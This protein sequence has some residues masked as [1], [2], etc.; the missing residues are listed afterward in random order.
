MI[1]SRATMTAKL[2][3]IGLLMIASSASALVAAEPGGKVDFAND[4][5]PILT[6]QCVECHGPK[7]QENG[8]RLDHG[9]A[10]VRGGD[11]GPAVVAGK[12]G[13]SLLIQAVLGTSDGV[14]QMPLKKPPLGEKEVAV[15]R[16]WIDGGA[17]V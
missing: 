8:L 9:S 2:P 13:D 11:S 17:I 10:L 15:L 5:Q 14:S 3:V 1:C 7:K 16:R 4:V 12:S 6:A